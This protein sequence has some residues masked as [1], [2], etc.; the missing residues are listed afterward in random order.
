MK[1]KSLNEDPIFDKIEPNLDELENF[2]PIGD[3]QKDV[4]TES[5]IILKRKQQK[6]MGIIQDALYYFTVYFISRDDKKEFFEKAGMQE[7][8]EVFING[9]DFAQK[10][11]IDIEKKYVH[12]PEPK[13]K[14]RLK[15]KKSTNK[16]KIKKHAKR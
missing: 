8:D 5:K 2:E 14:Q 4:E 13:F 12:L 16:L 1:K 7:F 3:L 9:Y 11:G 6:N 10:I 15:I